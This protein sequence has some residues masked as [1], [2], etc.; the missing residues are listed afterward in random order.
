MECYNDVSPQHLLCLVVPASFVSMSV[1]VRS[2]SLVQT[3]VV[4][5]CV[6]ECLQIVFLLT[7]LWMAQ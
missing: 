1:Y 3:A 4:L 7:G 5:L 2:S 6:C